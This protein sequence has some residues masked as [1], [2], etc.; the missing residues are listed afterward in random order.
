MKRAPHVQTSLTSQDFR[1]LSRNLALTTA[2]VIIVK[3]IPPS[4]LQNYRLPFGHFS[5]FQPN[6]EWDLLQKPA[7]LISSFRDNLEYQK[8]EFDFI[9]KRRPQFYIMNLIVPCILLTLISCFVFFLPAISCKYKILNRLLR[10]PV[11][12]LSLLYTED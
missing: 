10:A 2:V 12:S 11:S 4:H 1:R 5:A 9:I 6:G 3:L 8:V 7:R